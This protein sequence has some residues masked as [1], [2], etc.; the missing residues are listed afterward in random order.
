MFQRRHLSDTIRILFQSLHNGKCCRPKFIGTAIMPINCGCLG[1]FVLSLFLISRETARADA[2]PAQVRIMSFNIRYGTA[3]DGENHWRRRKDFLVET[4]RTFSPDLLGTQETLAFQR[5]FLAMK[6]VDYDHSGVGRNDGIADGEMT[7]LFYKRERFE[8]LDGGHFW[9]S[10][11]PGKAGS[12]SWDSALPRMV[13]WVKLRDRKRPSSPP[14]VFFNTHFDHQGTVARFNSAKL[15]RQQIL[16]LA[17]GGAVIVTGDF[18]AGEGSEPYQVLF[19][20]IEDQPSPVRDSYRDAHP[21]KQEL[22]GT[23][24]NFDAKPNGG[25]RIDWI[26][27][28]RDWKV[29]A[30]HIDRTSE[31]GRTPSDHFPV[32]AIVNWRPDSQGT[33]TTLPIPEKELPVTLTTTPHFHEIGRTNA[34]VYCSAAKEQALGLLDLD[35]KTGH[36]KEISRIKTPGEPAAI[37]TSPDG[38]LLFASMRSTGKLTSFRIDQ[39]T[40]RLTAVNVVDAGEDP[41][42]IS[43]DLTGQYLLTAYYVAAKVSVHRIGRDGS[44][45]ERPLQEVVTQEKAHAI[46]LD[47]S[48][49]FAFVPHTG[50]NVIFQFAWNASN[51]HLTPHLEAKVT[52]PQM[53]GPR[54]VAWHPSKSIA[55]IDNEQASSVT[56]YGLKED[57]SLEPVQTVSTLPPK[58]QG[59]N[60]TAEI[61]VHPNGRF[62]YVSNRGHDSLAVIKIDDTGNR[63]SFVS[64]E[65]TEKTPRSFDIDP[66]GEF[67]LSAGE[68]S[69]RL[70]VSRIDSQSGGLTLLNTT[71]IGPMLWWVKIHVVK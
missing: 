59:A 35:L 41:A 30:A 39:M 56:A 19:D 71:D 61:K 5:D 18:N 4:I 48:N 23:F 28:S 42:Q 47:P 11:S 51:G 14:L 24:S 29:Q 34:F 67:L 33:S 69:G 62:L 49:R 32:T 65:P 26:G 44:L 10:E 58:F 3:T 68:S 27:V 52:R 17:N 37:T 16:K 6:L 70:A 21:Q 15:L 1:L 46:A 60:S 22:E 13:T 31:A 9:L 63:L 2:D 66:S 43:V 57:G 8:K 64:A 36:V 45:S 25:A 7:A 20:S 38:K 54:H 40:G 55:Y 12:K 53:T 50:P